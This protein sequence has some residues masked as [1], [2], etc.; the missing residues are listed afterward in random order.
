MSPNAKIGV[1]G[2]TGSGKSTFAKILAGLYPLT[3]GT[4]TIGNDS[5]YDLTH[6]EQT[7]QMTLVL[8]ETEI[9][10]FSL[11]DNITLM[12]EVPTELFAEA[13]AIAQLNE[14]ITKL[15]NGLETPLGERGYHLSGG[16]RQRVGIA[17]APSARIRLL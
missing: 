1:V 3:S 4:Y 2:K 14:M 13:L 11:H 17:P 6:D 9:F 12:R 10:N 8:Q 7:S 16:E 5:F 15:P